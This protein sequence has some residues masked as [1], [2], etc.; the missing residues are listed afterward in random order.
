MSRT[1]V[2][3]TTHPWLR[4]APAVFLLAWGGNHF[5]PLLHVYETVSHYASWQANLLLG[6]YV[7]GLIPGLLI[8]AVLSDRHGRRPVFLAGLLASIVASAILAAGVSSFVLLCLG[9]VL[10][11]VGVGVAM[12]VGTSW[13]KELSSAPFEHG[14][15]RV[16]GARRSSLTLTVGFAVGAGVT[17][18]LAQFAPGPEVVPYLV[19]GVLGLVALP[20]VAGAPETRAEQSETTQPWWQDLRVPAAGHRRFTHVILPAAPWVFGAA[21]VAYAIIPAGVGSNLGGAATL[22]ATG[23]T[24]LTLGTGALV[25]TVTPRLD[26]LTR[27]HA[28]QIGMVAM[29]VGMGVAVIATRMASPVLGLLVAVLLGAAYGTVIVAGLVRVQ[30]MAGPDD[31][32][33]LTGV[34]YALSYLGFLLP[35][36]LA[37]ALPV[38][39]YPASL[40]ILT[41]ACLACAGIVTLGARRTAPAATPRAN[42]SPAAASAGR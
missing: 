23:L 34:Y 32:A 35:A 12:S 7:F 17:G 2:S 29:V 4:I 10:A 25:Q 39:T 9:R 37:A 27:G 19:H 38:L 16:A 3:P 40:S 6:M 13:I 42:A 26:T 33:G 36:I 15:A 8:A 5:T 1:E 22:Y 11:G 14:A 24:V 41:L 21:G 31:L 20:L 28:L 18:L 30:R